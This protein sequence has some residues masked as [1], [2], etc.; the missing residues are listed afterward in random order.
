[1]AKM[2]VGWLFAVTERLVRASFRGGY[3]PDRQA[4]VHPIGGFSIPGSTAGAR[5][6]GNHFFN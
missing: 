6:G 2:G 4:A 3:F 1:M 5:S